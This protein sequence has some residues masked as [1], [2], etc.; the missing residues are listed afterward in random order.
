MIGS[1][2]FKGLSMSSSAYPDLHPGGSSSNSSSSRF[3]AYKGYG[4]PNELSES[5]VTSSILKGHESMMAVLATRG[6]NLEITH[7]LWQNKDAKAGKEKTNKHLRKTTADST[8][9]FSLCFKLSTKRL[10]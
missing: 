3:S 6:R 2:F 10:T 8:L 9:T 7:K 5:E 4:Q 1:R